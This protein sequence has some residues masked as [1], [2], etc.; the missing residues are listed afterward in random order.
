[1]ATL[2]FKNTAITKLA[3]SFKKSKNLLIFIGI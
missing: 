2:Q 3:L 1:M